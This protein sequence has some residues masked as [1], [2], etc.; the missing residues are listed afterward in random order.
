[1][2]EFAATVVMPVRNEE[3]H[4]AAAL[5]A[6]LAQDVAD[7]SLEVLVVDGRSSDRTREIVEG[8]GGGARFPVRVLDNPEKIAATALN[9]GI[10]AARSDVVV[11]VDGH[12]EIPR[13]YVPRL[14]EALGRTGSDVVGGAVA[15]VGTG[16]YARSVACAM[17]SPLGHGGATFRAGAESESDADT[18]AYPAYRKSAVEAAGG[19]DPEMVRNQDDD[20]HLRLRRA[21]GRIVFV[22]GCVS[23]VRCRETRRRVF[24]QYF[25][26][27]FWKVVGWRRRGELSSRRAL[28][29]AVLVLVAGFWSLLCASLLVLAITGPSTGSGTVGSDW[30][31]MATSGVA[32]LWAA[33]YVLYALPLSV[34][35][36]FVTPR[37]P[38]WGWLLAPPA[39]ILVD[40]HFAY[41]LGFWWGVLRRGRVPGASS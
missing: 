23:T 39:R 37:P 15:P 35:S 22:P 24:R 32:L 16:R 30:A 36:L 1:V 25:D 17:R 14:L 8:R 11:R 40:M 2:P 27:G 13:D 10:A 18:V 7:G 20:L 26:Y 9:T 29:P 21:G 28:A 31:V 38:G 5:D 12:C 19:F 41:G 6:V 34:L 4:I 3:R 33:G